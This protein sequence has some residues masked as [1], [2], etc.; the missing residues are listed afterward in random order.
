MTNVGNGP[1]LSLIVTHAVD[2]GVVDG[3]L[4]DE[5]ERDGLE[6][7]H[8]KLQVQKRYHLIVVA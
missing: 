7:G 4:R 6:R 8:Q 3:K 1:R 2:N 5:H